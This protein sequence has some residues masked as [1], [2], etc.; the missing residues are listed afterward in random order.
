MNV[1][2]TARYH[3]PG[4]IALMTILVLLSCTI[5]QGACNDFIPSVEP[6]PPGGFIGGPCP[7]PQVDPNQGSPCPFPLDS[8]T[9]ASDPFPPGGFIGG[10]CPFPQVDPNQGSPCPF[11]LDSS[12]GASD[13]F[14]PGGFIGGP[15]PFPQVDPNQGSPCPFSPQSTAGSGTVIQAIMSSAVGAG[16]DSGGNGGT[17]STCG[18]EGAQANTSGS[19]SGSMSG[20]TSGN[21]NVVN[22]PL[23]PG[24]NTNPTSNPT[25]AQTIVP[26]PPIKPVPQ[27]PGQVKYSATGWSDITYK[28]PTDP[29]KDGLYEDL[30]GDGRIDFTDVI[31]LFKDMEWIQAYEP[32]QYFDFDGD[33]LVTFKDVITVFKNLPDQ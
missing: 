33:H 14:A 23:Y 24:Q 4:L 9:G 2:K 7:F 6:F 29:N 26:Q 3:R 10:P 15:C 31:L 19:I 27:E 8:S 1:F 22:C 17:G 5:V 11:P 28:I 21:S 13:P 32:V 20:G 25:P 30:N 12:T 16:N 18:T